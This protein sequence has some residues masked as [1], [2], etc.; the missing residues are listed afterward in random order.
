MTP[1]EQAV[2]DALVTERDQ[3]RT[4]NTTLAGERDTARAEHRDFR[5][6]T[7]FKRIAKEK[8]VR[9]KALETFYRE[10]GYVPEADEVDIDAI[11]ALIDARRDELDY[12]FE[13]PATTP[14]SPPTAPPAAR[15]APGASRGAEPPRVATKFRVT[16]A[17]T[18]DPKWIADNWSAYNQ[19][20]QENRLEIVM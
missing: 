6:A 19:A 1:E 2:Y 3:L 7:E 5:H 14:A 9:P 8:G 16:M 4:Q 11:T 17:Q 10:S 13:P 12:L 18:S 20:S 15:P